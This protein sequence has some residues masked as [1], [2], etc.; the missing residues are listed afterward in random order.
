MLRVR[1]SQNI[2]Y[3]FLGSNSFHVLLCR[4]STRMDCPRCFMLPSPFVRTALFWSSQLLQNNLKCLSG[5][6][7]V[8]GE[9]TFVAGLAPTQY[10]GLWIGYSDQRR[11]GMW[12]WNSTGVSGRY[13]NWQ[14]SNGRLGKGGNNGEQNCAIIWVVHPG[15]TTWDDW[16]C[17][18]IGR[19]VCER[20]KF[21]NYLLL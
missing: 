4:L 20:G 6:N 14:P 9:N 3:S 1:L 18:E 2:S 12:L 11:E 8:P 5:G 13:T 16:Y 15:R 17:T 7:P 10:G 19:F 21:L